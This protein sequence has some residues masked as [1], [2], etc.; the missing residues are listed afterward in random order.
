[1][2]ITIQIAERYGRYVSSRKLAA[3]LSRH[4]AMLVDGEAASRVV[5]DFHGVES[6]STSFTDSLLG[7]LVAE[8]GRRWLEKHVS[9]IGIGPG[10]RHDIEAVISLRDAQAHSMT[11]DER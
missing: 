4:V 9:I 2:I 5:I 6:I 8:R 11:G 10:D 1:M 7:S 3:E